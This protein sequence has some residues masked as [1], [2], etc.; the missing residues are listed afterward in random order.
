M[1][2][3]KRKSF[4]P[5]ERALLAMTWFLS[6]ANCVEK[7]SLCGTGLR[8]KTN[9]VMKFQRMK[10]KRKMKDATARKSAS[11]SLISISENLKNPRCRRSKK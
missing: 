3:K 4:G 10:K 9:L 8:K 6:S 11:E 2:V 7:Q 1:K 5:V